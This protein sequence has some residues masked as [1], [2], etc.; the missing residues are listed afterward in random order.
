MRHLAAAFVGAL[1]VFFWGFLAYAAAGIWDFAYPRTSADT[2]IVEA[3]DAR[4][5]EDGAYFVPSMTETY[6]S[7]ATDP[8]AV[9][10]NASFEE[11]LAK[12]PIALVLFRKDGM[13]PMAASELVRGF[14][15]EFGAALLLACL[16]SA[17]RGGVPGRIFFGFTV[18][19][20]TALA[21][22]GVSG[23]FF[24]LPLAFM[25]ANMADVVIGWTA[26]S[27]AIAVVLGRGRAAVPSAS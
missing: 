9:A 12:G 3:L 8:E 27:I 2:E 13:A 26:A 20:F 1:V 17:A 14:A 10:A 19:L 25:Y 15:I 23:N 7:G 24:H 5:A 21:S 22:W 16:L 6:M 11:R 4:L 18:A